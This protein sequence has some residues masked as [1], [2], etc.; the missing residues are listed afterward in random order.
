MQGIVIVDKYRKERYLVFK[1]R[2]SLALVNKITLAFGI[3]CLTGLMA[4]IRI[5]LPWT[6]VPITN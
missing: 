2:C 6:P 4:Q 1:W 3:A 5:P